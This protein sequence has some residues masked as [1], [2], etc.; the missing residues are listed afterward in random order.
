MFEL[1]AT[2]A[3]LTSVTPRTEKHGDADVF[4]I[5]LGI[6]LTGANTLLDKL[7]PTLRHALYKAVE[8]QDQLPGVEPSTPLLRTR[9]MEEIKLAGTFEGWTVAIDHGIDES[10]PIKLGGSKVDKL[11]VV[12]HEGGSVD[13]MFRVGS[14]DIDATE[15]GL[16]CS[17]LAQDI[18]ITLVAPVPVADK[19]VIDGTVGHPGAAAAAAGQASAEDLFAAGSDPGEGDPDEHDGDDG[20]GHPDASGEQPAEPQRGTNWPF[21]GTNGASGETA[22]S[23]SDTSAAEQAELEAG[24]AQAIKS[25]GVKP[26][27]RGR[28]TAAVE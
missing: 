2:P 16:L 4:A 18:E 6:K 12:P 17:H 26:A 7:S 8:G 25:A 27:R 24:M 20:S 14:S 23:D 21:P 1:T 28:R 11:R 10:D 22:G 9:G 19:P 3:K 15:A 13:L 5:S